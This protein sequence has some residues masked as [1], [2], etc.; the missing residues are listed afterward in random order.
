M[1]SSAGVAEAELVNVS[2]RGGKTRGPVSGLGESNVACRR[3]VLSLCLSLIYRPWENTI[4]RESSSQPL[5]AVP[6]MTA[7][8]LSWRVPQ[9]TESP[10]GSDHVGLPVLQ[11]KEFNLLPRQGVECGRFEGW[12]AIA[13]GWGLARR[14][15]RYW[16]VTASTLWFPFRRGVVILKA[17]KDTVS[18]SDKIVMLIIIIIIIITEK[19]RIHYAEWPR[20][21]DYHCSVGNDLAMSV[22]TRVDILQVMVVAEWAASEVVSC[23]CPHLRWATWMALDTPTEGS[24]DKT[25][26]DQKTQGDTEVLWQSMAGDAFTVLVKKQHAGQKWMMRTTGDL[27]VGMHYAD[28]KIR[29]YTPYTCIYPAIYYWEQTIKD[30]AR[31]KITKLHRP[32]YTGPSSELVVSGNY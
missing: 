7:P 20:V 8:Q 3:P 25:T 22:R 23:T 5:S 4:C 14:F 11:C 28:Q 18:T 17:Q 12:E 9:F 30:E 29:W 31:V 24:G 16:Q 26:K 21:R 15:G 10:W 27:K 1:G 6:L 13:D 19:L 32:I 2:G